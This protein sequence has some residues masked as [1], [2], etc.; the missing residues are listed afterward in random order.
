MVGRRVRT[1]STWRRLAGKG[2]YPVEYASW[3]LSPLRHLVTP[4]GR[5]ADRLEL[6]STDHV[7]EVGCGPGYFSPVI[8]KR[9]SSGRLIL[10]D[11]QPP[12]LDLAT[13]RMRSRRLTNFACACGDARRLP[14]GDNTFDVVMMV[15]ALGEVGD[16]IA[17]IREA[18]RVLRPNGRLSITEALGDPDRVRLSQLDQLTVHA[19]LARDRRWRGVLLSTNNF[20]KLPARA[21]V[22]TDPA[23]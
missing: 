1:M 5:I 14:F 22:Q 10:F 6:S 13:A 8:A 21:P 11:V 17:S 3:L 7:L 2:I 15:T 9:L 4:P 12:M 18:A 16:P 20:R 23:P 19:G